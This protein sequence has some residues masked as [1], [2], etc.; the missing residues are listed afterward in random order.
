[1]IHM[2]SFTQQEI[3]NQQFLVNKN[4]KFCLVQITATGLKK[5]ILD[6]TAPMR[7]YFVENN[8]HNYEHQSQ[9]P[10]YKKLVQTH[11]LTISEDCLT[12]TSLY[13]PVTKMGDPRLWIYKL[14]D[15]TKADDIHAII[16]VGNILYVINITQTNIP[17]CCSTVSLRINPIKELIDSLFKESMSV[18]EELLEKFRAD[19][20]VWHES[21]VAADT[22]IGRTIESLL[23]IE[24]NSSKEADYK[25]IELKSHREKR[26]STKNVLF[27]QTPDWDI[28]RLKKG[29]DIV[30]NY[31]Y[32]VKPGWKTLQN[33]LDCVNPNSQGLILYVN[34]LK[35]LLEMNYL[36]SDKKED[37]AV[38]RLIKLH[39]RLNSKHHETFWIEVKNQKYDG[40]EY[41]CYSF[42]EHTK[43]PNIGQF[44]VLLEQS[45]ITL[46]LMLHRPSGN[47]DTYSFKIKKK[48]MPLLFPESVIYDLAMNSDDI[49]NLFDAE[50][51]LI[52]DFNP[53]GTPNK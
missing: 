5:S 28:S 17:L 12:K 18:A 50:S 45:M 35:E 48:A 11:I 38:W 15:Y 4:I 34:Q 32:E 2:R 9:G 6:A 40:K 24:M 41:F 43:N 1:M 16:A 37:V 39:E 21:E 44:D 26:S 49:P 51:R 46:D 31:G 33:T 53:L 14:T 23:G 19:A 29:I 36:D 52:A 27:T 3:T 25:G 10:E 13:R 42:I 22:G 30:N 20:G 47:G 7:A 8:I